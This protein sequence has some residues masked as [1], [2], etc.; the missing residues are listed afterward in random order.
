MSWRRASHD[1]GHDDLRTD[2]RRPRRRGRVVP[3]PGP[4]GRRTADAVGLDRRARDRRT[5]AVSSAI[6]SR[7]GHRGRSGTAVYS[8]LRAVRTRDAG[9]PAPGAKRE[10]SR[11]D[12]V[13]RPSRNPLD[14]GFHSRPRPLR[15]VLPPVAAAAG[16]VRASRR[17]WRASP[18]LG[19][20]RACG[21]GV[22]PV[23]HRPSV[24]DFRSRREG[25]RNGRAART[26]TRAGARSGAPGG[27]A[28]ARLHLAVEPRRL[29]VAR[30]APAG[31]GRGLRPSRPRPRYLC[32]KLR[33][34]SLDGRRRVSADAGSG[35]GP[36]PRRPL[37]NRKETH[38]DQHCDEEA[39]N[40]GFHPDR[41]SRVGP[42]RP[43]LRHPRPAEP[44]RARASLPV[45]RCHQLGGRHQLGND[46][47]PGTG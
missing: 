47:R 10:P 32:A 16:E 26:G 28:S 38:D 45:G 17:L 4:P 20:L 44:R 46:G 43:R 29:V 21:R 8:R 14:P 19:W 23:P 39:P 13:G 31:R 18:A 36:D 40:P 33:T 42:V 11:R 41:G 37:G 15:S 35:T 3:R 1:S 24:V 7:R 9:L 34:P 12:R 22:D 27:G 6:P 5:G 30:T 25:T 2:R